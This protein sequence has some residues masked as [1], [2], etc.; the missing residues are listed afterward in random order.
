M[1]KFLHGGFGKVVT[2]V[3]GFV[4]GHAVKIGGAAL[5]TMAALTVSGA[6]EWSTLTIGLLT[7]CA[8]IPVVYERWHKMLK[9]RHEKRPKRRHI[10]HW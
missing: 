10:D 1:V 4:S 7:I 3:K 5:A 9:H 8:M 6:T 2:A